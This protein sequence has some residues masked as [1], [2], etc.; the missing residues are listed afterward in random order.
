MWHT[1]AA[2]TQQPNNNPLEIQSQIS[3]AVQGISPKY[4]FQYWQISDICLLI[5]DVTE[6]STQDIIKTEF[7]LAFAAVGTLGISACYV[8]QCLAAARGG[9]QLGGELLSVRATQRRVS[10]QHLW[11]KAI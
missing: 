6:P 4:L 3:I 2:D 5:T 8:C 11:C 10:R 1:P 9:Q 7:A